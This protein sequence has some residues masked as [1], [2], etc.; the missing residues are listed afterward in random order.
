[1]PDCAVG[2]HPVSI[3]RLPH[4][5]VRDWTKA[6]CFPRTSLLRYTSHAEP[7][8]V[9]DLWQTVA[10]FV[11]SDVAIVTEHNWINF[12]ALGIEADTA[13]IIVIVLILNGTSS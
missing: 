1:M 7:V 2:M 9:G 12:G 10:V 5:A 8:V 11:D 4:S 13:E 3:R 6:T